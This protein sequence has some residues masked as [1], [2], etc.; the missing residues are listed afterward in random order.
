MKVIKW[1]FLTS[2]R[3]NWVE[4]GFISP[5]VEPDPLGLD[6]NQKIVHSS[7][8]S[9]LRTNL[10]REVMSFRDFPFVASDEQ[11][12]PFTMD[13]KFNHLL[14]AKALLNEDT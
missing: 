9:S 7:L 4:P 6:P 8:Y 2:M 11:N 5:E 14:N 12:R 3:P 10:P 1:W 13:Q